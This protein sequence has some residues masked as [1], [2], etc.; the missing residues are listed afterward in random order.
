MLEF[1]C[2]LEHVVDYVVSL[3]SHEKFYPTG[4]WKVVARSRKFSF[5]GTLCIQLLLTP[6]ANKPTASER[7]HPA[8]V[9]G[10]HRVNHID[11]RLHPS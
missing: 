10:M 6:F 9:T 11:P 4:V 8:G 3:R 1:Y 7:H 5:S 2:A